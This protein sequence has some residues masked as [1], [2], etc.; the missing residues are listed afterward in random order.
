MR[1]VFAL[2]AAGWFAWNALT[3]IAAPAYGG[4]PGIFGDPGAVAVTHAARTLFTGLVFV[5]LALVDWIA[6][7]R[8]FRDWPE[9]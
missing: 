7:V 3:F 5:S 2:V 4:D 1:S 6:I 8:Q 9:P